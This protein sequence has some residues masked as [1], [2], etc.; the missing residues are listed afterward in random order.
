[1][2]SL[3]GDSRQS[4]S[5]PLSSLSMRAPSAL[6]FAAS[7]ASSA[8][9]HMQPKTPKPSA[10]RYGGLAERDL[11]KIT[12][13]IRTA[14]K[15]TGGYEARSERHAHPQ[16]SDD[17]Q[18]EREDY[19]GDRYLPRTKHAAPSGAFISETS[20]TRAPLNSRLPPVSPR[21]AAAS[22]ANGHRARQEY[23]EEDDDLV[24]NVN[25]DVETGRQ[26]REPLEDLESDLQEALMVE[27]L[28]FV[29][30][31][32]E[33]QYIEFDSAY[34]PEDDY[35]RLQGAQFEVNS[36]LD[37]WLLKVVERF[38]PLATHYTAVQ[39]FVEQYSVLE[40]GV[41][42]HALCAAIREMLKE[43][44]ILIAQLEHQF[45]TSPTFSLQRLWFYVHPTVH[46]MSLIFALTSELVA[47]NA[48]SNEDSSSDESTEDDYGGGEAMRGILDEMKGAAAK[49]ADGS[50]WAKGP[51][52]GG[53]VL[54][55]LADRLERTSGDPVAREL[56][57]TLLLRA[58]QPYVSI[59]LTWITSGHLSDPWDEFIVR[60]SRGI[61]RGSLDVDYTDEYWDRRYTLRDKG[62]NKS[63][64]TAEDSHRARGLAA[65]AV[66]PAFLEPW[67]TKI[68]LAGKYLNVMRECGLEIA[69]P[70]S[71][72]NQ[73]ELIAMNEESFYKR[74]DD[75]Y[76]YA[77]KTLLRLL[78]DDQDL[79]S[80]LRSIKQYFFVDHGDAFNHF[81]DLAKHELSKKK[82]H[83]S[84]SKLQSLLELALRHPSSASANDPFKDDL[85]I[86]LG[87]STLTEWLLQ[88]VNVKGGFG[89]EG[90]DG[91][92][93]AQ[94]TK[95]DDTASKDSLHAWEAL[96][97][98]YAVKFPLSLVISRKTILRYQ[99]LFRHL[100]QLKHAERVLAETWTEH[101]K[102]ILWRTRSKYSE[103]EAW[104]LRVFSLRAR[105]FAFIQQMYGFAV[106][107][108]LELNWTAL[109]AKL[110]KVDTVDQLLKDHVD[111]LDTCLKECLL[112]NEKLL[113][114]H[115]KLLQV[116]TLF[117]SYTAHFTKVIAATQAQA[118]A[119][120]QDW[121]QVQFTKQW[122]FLDKFEANFNHHNKTNLDR[123]TYHA[124]RENAQLLPL[125]VRLTNLKVPSQS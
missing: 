58:S 43:Y 11:Q 20:F 13:S 124:S 26:V 31:G 30:M 107:G 68:L 60:E 80:R 104:K 59:L 33:G 1:M 102:S 77:N 86:T 40:Y 87:N 61:D 106:S 89:N 82:R 78:I 115:G 84:E 123:L 105:M 91:L 62:V 14:V 42:N 24:D 81:L 10:A 99:L 53:E 21:R 57:G 2:D 121:S 56:Y 90:G 18:D 29:L 70:S 69:V 44:L 122:E 8:P 103:L 5:R 27:D 4:R 67:K 37:P 17:G 76:T 95:K 9:H 119:A 55:V 15:T 64:M 38:L 116:C 46:T 109:E 47:L 23:D 114:L 52:R 88:I 51:A 22:K 118:E 92:G 7:T 83:A 36:Q 28:L 94:N 73:D 108:V 71:T 98:D 48:P 19:A 25:A 125:V 72:T 35:E 96:T 100:L 34:S 66:V 111:F 112:T 93:S 110:E 101:T 113:T 16:D 6:S 63:A 120:G 49:A 75:A 74:I 50:A 39:A 117:A 54:H 65:G 79:A 32:I 3:R 85:R 97:L 45:T 12:S 41:I